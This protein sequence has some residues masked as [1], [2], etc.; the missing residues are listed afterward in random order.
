VQVNVLI[1]TAA[2]PTLSFA[3]STLTLPGIRFVANTI[4]FS[5][6]FPSGTWPAGDLQ[7]FRIDGL[8]S[9]TLVKNGSTPVILG[10]TTIQSGDTL[11]WTPSPLGP[12]GPSGVTPV[13]FVAA[14]DGTSGLAS[15]DGQVQLNLVNV[16]PAIANTSA[17]LGPA[18][19]QTPFH[20]SYGSLLAATGATDPN[21]D[22]IQFQFNSISANGTLQI[23][24]NAVTSTVV[25][26]STV[27]MPGD[28]LTWT[29][30]NGVT[31]PAV[32]AFTVTAF[33]G[34]LTSLNSSA[35][36]VQVRP[37]GS[38]F[39]LS[40]V[41]TSSVGGLDR[42]TQTGGNL[43]F[44]N[45]SG[46]GSSG[47][48]I[49]GNQI[50]GFGQTGTID[51]TTADQGRIIW[52][53]GRIWLRISL[54]GE[55]SVTGGGPSG[56]GTI[57]EAGVG[58]TYN[59]PSGTFSGAIVS[60]T[61][62]NMVVGGNTLTGTLTNG[63]TITFSN[64]Q[65][66]TKLDLAPNYTTSVGGGAT[67]V[68]PTGTA[69]MNFVNSS[70]QTFLGNFTDATHVITTSAAS[71]FPIGTT[72]SIAGGKITWST[73]EVWSESL[74]VYGTN[75][76]NVTVS[77][78]VTPTSAFIINASGQISHVNITGPNSLMAI[79][80]ASA[81]LTATRTNGGIQWSNGSFWSNFDF[82]ALDAAF[83]F[84]IAS[85]PGQVLSGT[86]SGG[87]AVSIVST[88]TEIWIVNA[89]GQ[90]AHVQILSATTLVVTDGPSAGVTATITNPGQLTFSNG[91]VW[92][93]FNA[94]ALSSLFSNV[95][96]YPFPP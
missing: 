87:M 38:A 2:S 71:G 29:P 47:T 95:P 79:D 40:G 78:T 4:N 65:V 9:G 12:G 52:S 17:T 90:L 94:A 75:P 37:F 33:D 10:T 51:T 7:Q 88:A 68:L 24:H 8:N 14:Y 85:G 80:G 70:N 26:N 35:I 72:A 56:L 59:G 34:S 21:N 31:G 11:T 49:S 22:A 23:T 77:L 19:Q 82:N 73:G 93:N 58:L 62:V 39:D 20:I 76:S 69:T 46:V 57:T 41:W 18:D 55:W 42:I 30:G 28:S 16:R 1:S 81:G 54:G 36:S 13:F 74:T 63:T 5:D 15:L 27:M 91:A 86:N 50:T 60:P 96:H 53:G 67:Q 89:A 84:N 48:Y 66:W 45:Q 44:V 92:S 83:A 3:S 61:Q 43:T 32:S 64:N 6:L 25:A